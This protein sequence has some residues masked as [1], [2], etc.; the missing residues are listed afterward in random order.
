MN[1]TIALI[2]CGWLGLPLA[3]NL[4]EKGYSINGSTTSADKLHSLKEVGINAFK[5]V[6]T[7]EQLEGDIVEFLKDTEIVVINV[8]PKL[9]GIKKENY[10]KK[11]QL[12]HQAIAQ[13]SVQKIL[14]ISSTAVYGAVEGEVSE[15]TEPEPATESGRQMLSAE[16]IFT[17]NRQFQTT[18]LRF[19]GLIGGN[20]H[21][22]NMLSGRSNLSNGNH[23][24]NLIHRN[25]C[26]CIIAEIIKNNWWNELFNGV[27]PHHP[28][29]RDYYHSEAIKNNLQPPDYKQD[30]YK[31]GKIVNSDRLIFVKKYKFTTTI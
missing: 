31:K 7:E 2:G 8:P 11:M 20:R 4:I 13:S 24:I 16:N 15:E 9:R 10:V 12:L 23:A 22:I 29:K 6:I 28:K 3:K 5:I 21:P 1:K 14:F 27:Y 17:D 25:D 18:I 19:G 30:N 26:I